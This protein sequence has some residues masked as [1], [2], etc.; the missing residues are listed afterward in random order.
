MAKRCKVYEIQGPDPVRTAG[1][2]R[3]H[4]EAVGKEKLGRLEV[5]ICAKHQSDTWHLF[6]HDDWL[7]AVNPTTKPLTKR[8]NDKNGKK[9]RPKK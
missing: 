8:A 5:P 9:S 3:C 1:A 2:V 7:Y 4:R 6:V